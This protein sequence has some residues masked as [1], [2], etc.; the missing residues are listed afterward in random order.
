[1]HDIEDLEPMMRS[2][3]RAQVDRVLARFASQGQHG[4]IL[5]KAVFLQAAQ[6]LVQSGTIDRPDFLGGKGAGGQS[7]GQLVHGR[8]PKVFPDYGIPENVAR[9]MR[10]RVWEL[11]VQGVLAPGTKLNPEVDTAYPAKHLDTW[12]YFDEAMITTYGARVL[13]DSEKRIRVHDPDGYLIN[14]L[15]A[16]PPPDPEMMRYLEEGVAVFSRGHFLAA[17]V[18]LGVASERLVAVL[19]ESLRD[20]LGDP[21]GTEWFET[22]STTWGI[23]GQFQALSSKLAEAYDEALK[24]EN[25]K[26]PLQCV[27]TPTFH[28]I[29]IARNSIAHPEGRDFTWNE[30]S[31]FLHSFVQYF[32][33]VSQIIA[34]LRSNPQRT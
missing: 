6:G 32:I 26:D 4:P 11:Y 22:Y 2:D 24:S 33:Y 20:G 16:K 10:Q 31:G 5:V 8:Q 13:T 21:E 27:V 19:A 29:R 3:I 17:V 7:F 28:Q 25:L 30:V 12:V 34:L 23:K 18:L 1:M 15:N 9:L 14:F